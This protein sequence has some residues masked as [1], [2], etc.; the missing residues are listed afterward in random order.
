MQI[1]EPLSLTVLSQQSFS[2]N[3]PELWAMYR[4]ARE[5]SEL[6]VRCSE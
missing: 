4:G 6:L 2:I 1:I 3:Y 5:N